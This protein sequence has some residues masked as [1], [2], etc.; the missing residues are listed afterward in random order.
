M[1]IRN[2]PKRWSELVKTKNY[3]ILCAVITVV[4]VISLLYVPGVSDTV[5]RLMLGFLST[6]A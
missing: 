5:E 3:M 2:G 1:A 6:N 4:L